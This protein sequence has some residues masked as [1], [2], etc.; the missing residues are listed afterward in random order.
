[1]PRHKTQSYKAI[2][3]YLRKIKNSLPK[4]KIPHNNL[5]FRTKFI[6]LSNG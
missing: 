1:M 3:K 5:I 2:Y 6:D 4:D